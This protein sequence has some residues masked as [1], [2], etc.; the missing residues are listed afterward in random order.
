VQRPYTAAHY[1]DPSKAQFS[2]FDPFWELVS[3]PINA[4]AFGP[5]ATDNTFGQQVVFNKFPPA[6]NYS[7]LSG[8]QFFGEVNIDGAAETLTVSLRDIG[9]NVLFEKTLAAIS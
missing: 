1:F 8:Y 9:G 6:Q 5:A 7:P 4:G 2:D 3:G